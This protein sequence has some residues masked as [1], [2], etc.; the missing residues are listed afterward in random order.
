MGRFGTNSSAV[1]GTGLIAD[2]KFGYFT[3]CLNLEVIPVV[4]ADVC[5]SSSIQTMGKANCIWREPFTNHVRSLTHVT[6]QI[7]RAQLV[8]WSLTLHPQ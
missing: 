1:C 8:S 6:Q 3:V 4:S 5:S 7:R 2:G